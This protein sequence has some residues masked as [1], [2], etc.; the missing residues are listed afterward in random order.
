[1]LC[2]F[3]WHLSKKGVRS[4]IK[5]ALSRLHRTENSREDESPNG[6][7]IFIFRENFIICKE[8][9]E[10]VWGKYYRASLAS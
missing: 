9:W 3:S 6:G 1:M 4:G 8:I 10:G 7:I 5:T 2:L